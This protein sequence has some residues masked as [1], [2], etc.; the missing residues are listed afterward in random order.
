M[1]APVKAGGRVEAPAVI[2]SLGSRRRAIVIG[3]GVGGLATA[4]RLA[5]A[6]YRVTVLEQHEGPGGRAG[7]FESMGF[8]F[9]R[10]PS[11]VMM[12]EC[13]HQLFRD[14]GRRLEDYLSLVRCDPTYRLHFADGAT[15]EMTGQLDRLLANLE[16]IE[17]GCGPRAL[18]FL[19]YTGELYRRGIEFIN[20]NMHRPG[21]M[22]KV[23]GMGLRYGAGAL[24]DLQRMVG[25]Y[26]KDER[27]RQALTFQSL[28]LGLSPYDSLAI[29]GLLAYTEMAGGIYYPM[30]GMVQLPLALERLAVELGVEFR[31]RTPVSRLDRAGDHIRAAILQDGTRV[32]A[33]V[34]VTNAD[35]PYAHDQLVG[36]P[37]PGIDRK[38]FSCSVMLLYLGVN[39]TYPDLLHH[40]LVVSTDLR[41]SCR[42][43]FEDQVMPDD[44][45]FYVVA[46]TR[47]DPSMAP[48]G[49]ENLFVLVLA[50]SQNPARP[51]DWAVEGPRVEQRTLQRLEQFG[52]TNLR[53]H[54]VTKHLFTPA[55]FTSR[56]GNLRGEAFGLSHG[57]GQIG[58]FRPHNRHRRYRNLFFVGQSTHP[59]CGLPMVLISADCVVQRIREEVSAP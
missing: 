7:A 27:L 59:G 38:E 1:S 55:D 3:A 2:G 54:I 57:L 16:R 17:P 35:L 51:I 4:V 19:A 12:T 36:E 24:G 11:M 58:Y 8:T 21:S 13:W 48:P 14:V 9:D 52:L 25:R 56:Y 29:Y 5:H 41:A 42:Q 53:R 6:G 45:P 22:L 40:N 47:T 10:G 49:S 23:G 32:P 26:F 28:Y 18:E 20:R 50:P 31:Y 39:R 34:I 46:N 44:G 37:Y 33:D 15:L 43:L 30:G